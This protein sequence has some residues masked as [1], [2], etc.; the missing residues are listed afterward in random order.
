MF[1]GPSTQRAVIVGPLVFW[2]A[3][4]NGSVSL[5]A[6]ETDMVSDGASVAR[7]EIAAA[8]PLV[9]PWQMLGR[10][11]IIT[12]PARHNTRPAGRQP[13]ARAERGGIFEFL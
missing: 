8:L 12:Q 1:A 10:S 3:E 11:E 4:R 7:S 2:K 5:E 6:G 9:C 13:T